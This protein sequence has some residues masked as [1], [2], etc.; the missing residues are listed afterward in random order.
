M[1]KKRDRAYENFSETILSTGPTSQIDL[2]EWTLSRMTEFG[3]RIPPGNRLQRAKK[4]LSDI[5]SG[6]RCLVEEDE[7]LVVTVA[8]AQLTVVQMYLITRAMS[9]QP[10]RIDPMRQ[11]MLRV[12]L[13][14]QDI[15]DQERQPIA[16]NTQFE[17]YVTALL[18]MGGATVYLAEPDIRLRNDVLDVGIAAKRLSSPQKTAFVD[19]V[20]D[21]EDQIS[22]HGGE[23]FVAINIDSIVKRREDSGE[24]EVGRQQYERFHACVEQLNGELRVS[25]GLLGLLYFGSTVEWSFKDS[26]PRF[27]LYHFH[28]FLMITDGSGRE[29]VW[30]DFFGPVRHT[31]EARL[32]ALQG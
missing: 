9:R 29:K 26:R 14:G 20:K 31:M 30:G 8:E 17:L 18:A 10:G 25:E 6:R 28:S 5:N 7:E 4:L 27:G 16:R 24:K 12:M 1:M 32:R 21:G 15:E 3:V 13:G 2:A 19:R 11:K 23:G 22:R